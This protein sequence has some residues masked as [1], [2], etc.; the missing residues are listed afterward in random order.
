MAREPGVAAV[1]ELRDALQQR[2]GVRHASCWRTAP[3]SAAFSTSWPPYITA[4][5]S[6]RPATTPRSWVTRIIAM[7]R[8]LALLAEQVEDLGLHGHVERG[9]GLVGEQQRGA[10]GE[11]D[12][13]HHALAHAAGQLVRVLRRGGAWPRGCARPA[14]AARRWP[15]A[16]CLVHAE[17]DLQRLGDLAADLHHRVERRHRVLEDHRHLLAP[18]A[19]HRLAVEVADLAALE[20]DA[21]AADGAA[22]AGA[23]P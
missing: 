2:L 7:L 8:S 14:A 3:W 13:D 4:I 23:G 5:S 17:V 1:L 9:G 19:A 11:G 21:A 6:V 12:G 18:H 20:L 16:F 10:A 15:A 22:A